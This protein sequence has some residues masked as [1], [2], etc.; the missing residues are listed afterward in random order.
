MDTPMTPGDERMDDEE[1][2]SCFLGRLHLLVQ[3][4]FFL[5][6]SLI[7]KKT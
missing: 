5:Y 2:K 1:V 7:A 3:R 4:A 6:H